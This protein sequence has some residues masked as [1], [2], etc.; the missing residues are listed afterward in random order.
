MNLPLPYVHSADQK[1]RD[2]E[3]LNGLYKA[4]QTVMGKQTLGLF[5]SRVSEISPSLSHLHEEVAQ[6]K[7]TSYL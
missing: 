4:R 1:N 7:S 2:S 6:I 5:S 3:Q